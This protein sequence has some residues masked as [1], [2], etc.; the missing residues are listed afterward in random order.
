MIIKETK[1]SEAEIL[2]L[3]SSELNRAKDKNPAISNVS[4]IIQMSAGD[5]LNF[6][7]TLTYEGD[8]GEIKNLVMDV[9]L[10]VNKVL[11]VLNSQ[12]IQT[13]CLMDDRFRKVALVLKNWNKSLNSDKHKRLN[14]FSIYLLLL[15]F[16]LHK[17]YMIN[18]QS[19]LPRQEVEI[20]QKKYEV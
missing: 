1:K 5:L 13:Y 4:Q 9:D 2:R 10:T 8:G 3:I 6:R 11:E 14:S 18:L 12:L 19:H 20:S 15:A 7:Y 16:M 17:R